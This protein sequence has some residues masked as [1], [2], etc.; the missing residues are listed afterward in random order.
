MPFT[1]ITL[2]DGR[3]IPEIA[4]G[5]W[6]LGNGREV[7]DQVE[8]GLDT[9]FDH[10]DTAQVYRNEEEVGIAFHESGLSREEVWI[11]SKWS[12]AWMGEKQLSITDSLK[13]SLAKLKIEYL[14]LYLIH[15]ASLCQEQGINSCWA[16]MEALQAAGLVKSIGVSNFQIADLEVLLSKAKVVPAVN[17]ILIHPYVYHQTKPLI[18][19]LKTKNIVPEAYSALVPLTKG[20]DGTP[21]R[22]VLDKISE[23]HKIAPEQTLLGWVR[24]KGVII[25]T[26]SSKKER[27]ERYIA[28]GDIKL[29]KKDVEEIDEA[30]KKGI[31]ASTR[32]WVGRVVVGVAGLVG[33]AIW[34]ARGLGRL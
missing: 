32:A 16:E 24:T 20:P 9:G 23:K 4:Y 27:L 29:S 13:A 1:T 31:P 25:I 21:L 28:V 33:V 3:K 8:Q 18:A 10:L 7:I 19:Y 34:G 30:G 12:G 14:D 15:A 11:T 6:T 22:K 2:N 17:Q 5:S 26:T